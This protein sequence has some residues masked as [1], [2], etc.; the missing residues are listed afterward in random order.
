MKI[1]AAIGFAVSLVLWS[2]L[3]ALPVLTTG[4]TYTAEV[5]KAVELGK[6]GSATTEFLTLKPSNP[7]AVWG[8]TDK[9]LL[10]VEVADAKRLGFYWKVDQDR[11]D[12]LKAGDTVC[13]TDEWFRSDLFSQHPIGVDYTLGECK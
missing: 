6:K 7:N 12:S 3:A 10:K 5:V 1:L 8:I 9:G 4:S 2:V 11:F 13:F